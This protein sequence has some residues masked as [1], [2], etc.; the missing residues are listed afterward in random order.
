M[1]AT[2]APQSGTLAVNGAHLFYEATGAGP[3]IVLVSGGGLLDHRLWN[4]QVAGF[5]RA[6][7]VVRYDIRGIGRSTRPDATFSH[8]DDLAQLL[9]ALVDGPADIVGLSFGAAIAIDLALDHPALIRR[10]VVASPGLSSDRDANL[11]GLRPLAELA[12]ANGLTAVVDA[13]C[14]SPELIPHP[15]AELQQ[16]VRTIYAD[17]ADLFTSDFPLIRLWRPTSPPASERLSS[18]RAETLIAIGERDAATRDLAARIGGR[19]AT[20]SMETIPAA[21]HLMNLDSSEDFD[22]LV[23]SFL[24]R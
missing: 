6:H 11:H 23:L 22:R 15:T 4:P 3:A 24:D 14:A 13:L 17:N 10:L 19:I 8:G 21:G 7:R 5:A 12:R 1:S 20:S 18:I 16:L 9:R 2:P